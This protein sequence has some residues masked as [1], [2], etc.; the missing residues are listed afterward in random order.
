MI[1]PFGFGRDFRKRLQ[2]KQHREDNLDRL[3]V[4]VEVDLKLVAVG[5]YRL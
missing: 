1:A 4:W 2:W 3:F 5:S